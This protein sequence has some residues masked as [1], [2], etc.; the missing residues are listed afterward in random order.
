[1]GKSN[2]DTYTR[3]F[4]RCFRNPNLVPRIENRVPKDPYWV[5]NIFPKKNLHILHIINPFS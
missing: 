5:P 3:F 4:L 1:M 2:M